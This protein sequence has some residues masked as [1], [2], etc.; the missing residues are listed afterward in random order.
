MA[1]YMLH[2]YIRLLSC[3]NN[4]IY[5]ALYVA[6][7]V[8]GALYIA[9][10]HTTAVLG[11]GLWKAWFIPM[12]RGEYLPTMPKVPPVVHMRNRIEV[13]Y[14]REEITE[15]TTIYNTKKATWDKTMKVNQLLCLLYMLCFQFCITHTQSYV[16]QMLIYM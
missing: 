15:R 14:T 7:L 6:L 16:T 11:A 10:L 3:T 2:Y 5:G 4:T 8:Y 12:L 1:H 13:P 9:L